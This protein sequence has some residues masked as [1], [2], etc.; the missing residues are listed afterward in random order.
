VER[1]FKELTD[2]MLRRGVFCSLPAL[3]DAIE[4]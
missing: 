3:I 2:P 4:L 1:W